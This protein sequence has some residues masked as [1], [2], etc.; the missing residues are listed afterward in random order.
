MRPFALTKSE[1]PC[2]CST[3]ST[4]NIPT[5]ISFSAFLQLSNTDSP[6]SIAQHSVLPLKIISKDQ[7]WTS[8]PGFHEIQSSHLPERDNALTLPAPLC[9][10]KNREK[11][12]DFINRGING[13]VQRCP[14]YQDC[15]GTKTA[16]TVS[17]VLVA[18]SVKLTFVLSLWVRQ[19]TLQWGY[20]ILQQPL[21]CCRIKSLHVRLLGLTWRLWIQQRCA[22]LVPS[23][24]ILLP[25]PHP[26]RRASSL[27]SLAIKNVLKNKPI[28]I[29]SWANI[30]N[31]V[32]IWFAKFSILILKSI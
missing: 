19:V 6:S 8:K 4:A 28:F 17:Y 11:H 15:H 23:S 2:T 14:E 21:G 16:A 32:K 7:N 10:K 30:L 9:R 27:S 3:I 26:S 25:H 13:P 5:P 12:K 22:P 1:T 24:S 20:P 31:N 29:A 18:P